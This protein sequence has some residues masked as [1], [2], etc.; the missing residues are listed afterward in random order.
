MAVAASM[1]T[2]AAVANSRDGS[3]SQ[4]RATPPLGAGKVS[5]SH[6]SQGSRNQGHQGSPSPAP[7]KNLVPD[8]SQLK[9]VNVV[10][11]TSLYLN[12]GLIY[13]DFLRS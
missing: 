11:I 5:A 10:S 1:K 8:L 13:Q 6:K 9:P 12:L 2:P 7:V 4:H 3:Y